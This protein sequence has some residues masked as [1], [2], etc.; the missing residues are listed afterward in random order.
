MYF[1]KCIKTISVNCSELASEFVKRF[2]NSK[3]GFYCVIDNDQRL[4]GVILLGDIA[5][6]LVLGFIE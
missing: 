6:N 3:A 5:R 2:N 4:M 1:D